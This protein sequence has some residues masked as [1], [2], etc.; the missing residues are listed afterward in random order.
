MSDLEDRYLGAFEKAFD[1]MIVVDDDGRYIDANPRACDLFGLAK[2]ELLG[3][4]IEE[5]T[6]DDCDFAFEWDEFQ[7]SNGAVDTFTL[8]CADGERRTVEYTVSPNIAP[9]EHLSILRDLTE[10]KER[11]RKL[12][13]TQSKYRQLVEQNLIGIYVIQ[14]RE[15][16]Y[17]NPRL[18][19][20]FGETPDEMIGH[21]PFEWIAEED[22]ERVKENLRRREQGEVDSLKFT[23]TGKRSDGERIDFQV[24]GGRV[25]V[26]GR[27]A[28]L[29][30]LQDVT[31]RKEQERALKQQNERLEEFANIVSHDLRNPLN[32]AQGRVEL[33]Q[34]E[35]DTDHL[36]AVVKAHER[37]NI[38]ID[39]LLQLAQEGKV[40]EETDS[41]SIADLMEDCW[42][43][44]EMEDARLVTETTAIV[45]GDESRLM[46]MGENLIRNAV[47]H[48]NGDV[49]ITVGELK[50]G[51][52]VEDDGVGIP[53]DDRDEVFETGYSTSE[54]GTGFGLSIV[55]QV[56]EA[57]DWEIRVTE[58]S[59]GGA[60]FEITGVEFIG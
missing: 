47:E 18:A 48:S 17:V 4:S 6:P 40:V 58:G 15:F 53:K 21:S 11:E 3:R 34:Q 57:H 28:I 32:V 31:E 24:H 46:Q 13:E 59:E 2:D 26:D 60:R 39:D 38:L 35:C 27:P 44:V 50:D 37:I 8:I 41:V 55:K 54:E 52:F 9:G 7:N 36:D 25:E 1:A 16:T 30:A 5:F 20:I 29:G 10:R 43:N 19:E 45:R 22:H 14:D 23:V 33:A 42:Q 51:F 56:V 49:T 12:R